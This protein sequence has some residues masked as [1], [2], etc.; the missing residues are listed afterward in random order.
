MLIHELGHVAG[1]GH[2]PVFGAVMYPLISDT[3]TFRALHDDDVAAITGI[4]PYFPFAVTGRSFATHRTY[5][6]VVA[7][8]TDSEPHP[9]SGYSVSIDWGDGSPPTAASLTRD[10]AG[11][12]GQPP[13]AFQKT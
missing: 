3:Q 6:G 1:L 4:Y 2:S 11:S 5:A 12:T 10:V 13:V 7:V 8:F 9:S